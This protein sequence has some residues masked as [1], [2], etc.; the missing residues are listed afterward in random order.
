MIIYKRDVVESLWEIQMGRGSICERVCKK[1]EEYFKNN[2]PQRHISKGFVNL[3][4]ITSSKDS[5]KLEKSLC[6]MP[7]VFGPSDDTASRI[8]K[9]LSLSLIKGPRNFWEYPLTD[10]IQI[11]KNIYE[12]I[13]QKR[14]VLWNRLYYVAPSVCGC[15]WFLRNRSFCNAS[16]QSWAT[17]VLEGH[18][19]WWSQTLRDSGPPGLK[20]PSPALE[21]S[22]L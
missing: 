2:V 21:D 10:E 22:S 4:W 6:W 16:G 20:L 12:L 9:I 18:C 15:R 3:Q 11:L 14:L 5:E 17:I 19:V 8:S 7:V 13:Q 1:I